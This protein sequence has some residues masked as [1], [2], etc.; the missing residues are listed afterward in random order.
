MFKVCLRFGLVQVMLVQLNKI[1]VCLRRSRDRVR[2]SGSGSKF[3]QR[4]SM[5]GQQLRFG[6]GSVRRLR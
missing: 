4:W 5:I 1:L 6:S 2:I 3:G